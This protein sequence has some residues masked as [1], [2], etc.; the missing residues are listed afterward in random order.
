[1]L[2]ANNIPYR[3]REYTQNPL[4][5]AE[6]TRLIE[7]LGVAPV[8]LLRR[9]DKAFKTLGLTGEE[10]NEELVR[11]MAAHPTL[12]QRPIGVLGDKAV[13]G[14]PVENLLSLG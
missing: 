2:Q 13:V 3:Y 9:R 7:I 6:L 14:R 4:S 12:L 10:S 8:T 1:L 11:H 5:E